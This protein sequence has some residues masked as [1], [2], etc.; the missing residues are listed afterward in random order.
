MEVTAL[1]PG[2]IFYVDLRYQGWLKDSDRSTWLRDRRRLDYVNNTYIF[3]PL[4]MKAVI[5]EEFV[6]SVRFWMEERKEL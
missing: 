6:T 4:S 2:D 1:K 3:E 5:D